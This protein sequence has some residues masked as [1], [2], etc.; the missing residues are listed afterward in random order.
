VSAKGPGT[1]TITLA[2]KGVSYP[3]NVTVADVP[4]DTVTMTSDNGTTVPTTMKTTYRVVGN[5]GGGAVTQSITSLFSA[6][7]S[8]Q[9][10]EFASV[11]GTAATAVAYRSAPRKRRSRP[12]SRA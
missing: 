2:F 4:L 8:T 9:D 6:S 7:L 1:A 10:A 3:R 5:F 12:P 11:S